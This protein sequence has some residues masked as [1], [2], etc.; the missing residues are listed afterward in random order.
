MIRQFLVGFVDHDL[1][2]VREF[3]V[4]RPL[5]KSDVEECLTGLG[6]V[7]PN[8]NLTVDGFAFIA[9]SGCLTCGTFPNPRAIEF[10]DRLARKTGCE[11]ADPELGQVL[12]VAELRRHCSL[13]S[14]LLGRSPPS[15]TAG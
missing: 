6:D 10:I 9:C 7:L 8:G 3:G 11:I 1:L 14:Q 12:T 4:C 2:R 5:E 13:M 15:P